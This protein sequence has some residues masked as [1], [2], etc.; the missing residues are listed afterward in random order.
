MKSPLS[1]AESE[2]LERAR[3]QFLYWNTNNG[4]VRKPVNPKLIAAIREA[5][6]ALHKALLPLVDGPKEQPTLGRL[7]LRM[8]EAERLTAPMAS[9]SDELVHLFWR[10]GLLDRACGAEV[11]PRRKKDPRVTEWV[12]RA[13]SEWQTTGRPP[14]A[15]HRFGS[16]ILDYRGKGIP[17]VSSRS[18]I[19][20][21]L[22]E[23]KAARAATDGG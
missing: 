9:Y 16:A 1:V 6:R 4:V 21:A 11:R 2:A 23:W 22:A 20:L 10:T 15:R 13:A 8:Q 19:E 14:S 5:A 7:A 3:E 12:C 18:V 17:R